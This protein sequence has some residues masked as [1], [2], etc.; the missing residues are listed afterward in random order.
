MPGS[1][2]VY[3]GAFRSGGHICPS[4]GHQTALSFNFVNTAKFAFSQV[5]QDGH[6]RG[7]DIKP[8]SIRGDIKVRPAEQSGGAGIRIDLDLHGSDSQITGSEWLGIVKTDSTLFLKTPRWMPVDESSASTQ[9]SPCIYIS[10]TIWIAPGTTLETFGIDAETLSVNFFPGLDY[11]ITQS[12]D[13]SVFSASLSIKA[14]STPSKLSINSRETT[15]DISSGSVTGSYPLYDLLSI[16]TDSG[17]IDVMIEPK[18]ASRESVKP[19]VLRLTSNSGSVRAVTSTVTVPKRDYRADVY[20][21]S[22]SI[23][24]TLLHG[25]R[26]SLRSINGRITAN[27]YPVGD[28]DTRT[29]IESHCTSGSTDITL[30]SSISHPSAPLKKLFAYYGSTSGS[31][32]LRYPAQWEGT[33]VG[34]TLSGDIEIDW[35]GLRIVKDRKKTWLKRKIVGFK[36]SGEGK[37]VFSDSSGRVTLKG[38]GDSSADKDD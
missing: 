4:G 7:S 34:T 31:L 1:S 13:I 25:L 5:S 33:V 22:G 23:D 30:H 37:L 29:D 18:E 16:H 35:P 32:D 36:G 17:S 28:N 11:A 8:V 26:T 2:L 3:L 9:H 6:H 38:E 24:V 27:L 20:T 15:I 21:S 14:N 19:A 10:A 12:T